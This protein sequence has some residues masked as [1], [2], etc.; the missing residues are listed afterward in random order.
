MLKVLTF[1]HNDTQIRMDPANVV[2]PYINPVAE[3]KRFLGE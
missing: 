2:K 3:E 1:K